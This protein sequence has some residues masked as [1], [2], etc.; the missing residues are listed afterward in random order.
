MSGSTGMGYDIS[1]LGSRVNAPRSEPGLA[2]QARG[3]GR[4]GAGSAALGRDATAP[5][6]RGAG[7][8]P[9]GRRW[10]AIRSRYQP[11]DA[12]GVRRWVSKSTW[13]SPNR[14]WKPSAHSKLSIS[15]QAK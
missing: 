5:Q 4:R 15:D 2:G 14:W 8:P 9:A 12:F 1:D 7:Q 6:R 13:T 10:A 3:A 11:N